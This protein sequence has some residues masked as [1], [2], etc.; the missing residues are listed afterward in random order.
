[1]PTIQEERSADTRRRLLDATIEC[2]Y[3][4]GYAGAS[5]PDIARRARVSRGA[6]L[7]HFPHKRE[8]V[9]RALKYAFDLRLERLREVAAELPAAPE[10]RVGA[11]VDLLWQAFK[12][13][14]YYA[15]L[16]L[17][18]A[19]RTDSALR[20]AV[21]MASERFAW[22]V[23]EVFA[24]MFDL[25]SDTP[26]GEPLETVIFLMLEA[27]ALERILCASEEREEREIQPA[28]KLVKALAGAIAS[29]A[30]GA[31]SAGEKQ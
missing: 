30:K 29:S 22:G 4:R 2:L 13:P 18:V 3:E 10:A 14:I 17:V 6:Q 24:G 15:W 31:D 23:H 21:R 20:E 8:L 12:G 19:S 5:T 16:E 7:H 1:M 11:L 9:V 25:K 27:L 26:Y 28:L